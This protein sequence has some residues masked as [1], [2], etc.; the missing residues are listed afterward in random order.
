MPICRQLTISPIN[1]FSISPSHL[2]SLPPLSPF[3]L[4]G[5]GIGQ[6][7]GW[8][9]EKDQ[10]EWGPRGENEGSENIGEEWWDESRNK[11]LRASENWGEEGEREWGGRDEGGGGLEE[12]W[13][14]GW[15]KEQRGVNPYFQI[16]MSTSY[17]VQCSYTTCK[18]GAIWL[19][20]FSAVVNEIPI[21]EIAQESE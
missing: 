7:G 16:C 13:E 17:K 9:I 19:P 3:R 20:S 5:R 6:R 14:R 2:P 21:H 11:E 15:S 4:S 8:G 18:V 1:Y 10:G 12:G